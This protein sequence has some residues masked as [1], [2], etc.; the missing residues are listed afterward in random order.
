MQQRS[1]MAAVQAAATANAPLVTN[2]ANPSHNKDPS[3][4]VQRVAN[5]EK[6][7]ASLYTSVQLL[8]AQ[9]MCLAM[10]VVRRCLL[11]KHAG[12]VLPSTPQQ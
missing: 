6:P 11:L 4:W 1:T 5:G 9:Q 3:K 12:V 10:Q 8:T 2:T 7:H